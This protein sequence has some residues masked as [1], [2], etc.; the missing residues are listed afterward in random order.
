M[1]KEFNKKY[2]HPT[3]RKLVDMVFNGEYDKNTQISFS[4]IKKPQPTREIGDV[5]EDEQGNIWE[6]RVYGK[7]KKSKLTDTMAEVRQYLS[8][9]S[10]CKSES[11]DKKGQ[12]GS[13]DKKLI[14]KTG[15]CTGCLARKEAQIKY[16]GL[17]NEYETY[18]MT[19]N[20]IAYGNEVIEKL[21][22][23]YRDAKQEYEYVGDNGV[24]EK[25][26]LE[27]P[28]EEIKEEILSD[29]QRFQDELEEVIKANKEAYDKLKDKNYELVK[30]I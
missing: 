25:W 8:E 14:R 21:K 2:M 7:I 26:I 3:R 15:F 20:M 11:C 18:R 6:Q 30:N 24:A 16:D 17:W 29:I 9:I 23:A 13:T 12:F 19:S 22:E 1:A 5:W 4:D 28:V 10:R 27:K